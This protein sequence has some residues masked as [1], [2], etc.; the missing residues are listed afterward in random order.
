MV[1]MNLGALRLE[2]ARLER[3][4]QQ[5]QVAAQ[6]ECDEGRMSRLLR[7]LVLPDRVL[8]L[9]IER[10]FGVAPDAWDV[11]APASEPAA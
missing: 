8:A 4:L 7:G 3:G 9:R 2:R 11:P 10:E 5:K 1:G 6:V